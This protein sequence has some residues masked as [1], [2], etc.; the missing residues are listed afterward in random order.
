[1]R[2]LSHGS[3]VAISKHAVD[4]NFASIVDKITLIQIDGVLAD[5]NTVD[6]Q[7]VDITKIPV[8]TEI[9]LILA[10]D[11]QLQDGTWLAHTREM[12]IL[13]LEFAPTQ[14]AR[15]NPLP[16]QQGYIIQELKELI[17]SRVIKVD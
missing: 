3:L 14:D 8:D 16:L 12:L 7:K 1:M 6:L 13:F 15:Q 5:I 2:G 9:I 17:K 4:E 11:N 10:C